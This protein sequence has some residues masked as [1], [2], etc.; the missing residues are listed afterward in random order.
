MKTHLEIKARQD[1]I[2][3]LITNTIAGFT[4][5]MLFTGFVAENLLLGNMVSL[6]LFFICWVSFSLLT[7]SILKEIN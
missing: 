1:F 7:F 4:F 2:G 3:D 6:C 5:S